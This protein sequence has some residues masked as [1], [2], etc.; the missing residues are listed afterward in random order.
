VLVH[1]ASGAKE[2]E[3]VAAQIRDADGRADVIAAVL[4]APDEMAYPTPPVP[5]NEVIM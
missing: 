2:V 3:A 5:R 1:C 4:A